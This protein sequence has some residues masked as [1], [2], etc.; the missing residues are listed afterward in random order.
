MIVTAIIAAVLAL[1]FVLSGI[2]K[3]PASERVRNEAGH[4]RIPVPAY[5]SIGGIGDPAARALPAIVLGLLVVA[6]FV[7][8]LAFV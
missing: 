5:R 7:L 4:L 2:R 8:R 1:M 6:E 3:L